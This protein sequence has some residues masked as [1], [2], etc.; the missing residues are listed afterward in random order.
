MNDQVSHYPK[1][2]LNNRKIDYCESDQES[3]SVFEAVPVALPKSNRIIDESKDTTDS[4]S[5]ESSNAEPENTMNESNIFSSRN[6][7]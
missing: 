1:Q 3:E 2:N 5:D 4:E 6:N 7:Y